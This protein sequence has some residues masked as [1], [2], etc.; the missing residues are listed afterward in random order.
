MKRIADAIAGDEAHIVD[1]KAKLERNDISLNDKENYSKEVDQTVKRIDEKI[2]E[3][4]DEILPEAFAIMKDT[5]RRFAQ[6][7]T[8]GGDG[9]RL[10]PRPGR[11]RRISSPSRATRPYTPPTGSPAATI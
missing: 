2:E 6:N 1:L 11:R 8:G 4:L 10:R 5:A 7:E 3:Q 9:Q